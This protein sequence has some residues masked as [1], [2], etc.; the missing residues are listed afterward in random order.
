M[1]RLRLR[2]RL[3]FRRWRMFR[4]LSVDFGTWS[5]L[6]VGMV[7]LQAAMPADAPVRL[8]QRQIK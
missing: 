3:M 6:V 2:F 5:A 1:M 7:W 4:R 8:P